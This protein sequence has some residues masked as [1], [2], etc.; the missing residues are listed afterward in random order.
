MY[1]RTTELSTSKFMVEDL[2]SMRSVSLEVLKST[3]LLICVQKL[4]FIASFDFICD[5]RGKLFK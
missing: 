3:L 5:V 4:T 2:R 1:V